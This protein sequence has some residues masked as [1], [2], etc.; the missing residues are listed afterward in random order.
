MPYQLRSR[1]EADRPYCIP[2]WHP[3]RS[4]DYFHAI[5]VDVTCQP[6][7]PWFYRLTADKSSL[8]RGEVC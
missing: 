3:D 7:V 4:L 2:L 6:N 8:S 5:A 1:L